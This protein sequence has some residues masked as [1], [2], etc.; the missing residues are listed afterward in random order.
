MTRSAALA[1]LAVFSLVILLP[2][3]VV[4]V[5]RSGVEQSIPPA[6][7]P[8]A[9]SGRAGL[10]EF[11]V[12]VYFHRTG[13]IAALDL[14]EYLAGVVAAEMPA[15]FQLEAM[16]AQAVAARTYSLQRSRS[17]GGK[18]CSKSPYPADLCTDS[19]CCQA[20]VDPGEAAR[21]WPEDK[22]EYYLER[23]RQ[24]VQE[25]AGEVVVYRGSLIE[26]VYHSTC[27]GYTESSTA[28]WSGSAV[29]YLG[30][31]SCP[32]CS[33]SPRFTGTVTLAVPE[34]AALL[35]PEQSVPVASG[36]RLP[37]SV[38]GLTSGGRVDRM[39][40]GDLTLTGR[41]ARRL[42]NLPS[43]AFDVRW[44][45]AG[46]LFA[47]RGYGHGIGLCQYGSDGAAAAGLT[48]TGILAHYYPGTAVTVFGR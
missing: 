48:Y 38:L 12:E 45:D 7:Q 42:F 31:V 3:A 22:R 47:C 10:M 44:T 32:Y 6:P 29:P 23:V 15:S 8:S 24:A 9:P 18:G 2:A 16:K 43:A 25:T 5:G 41:E 17:N 13:E 40:L 14:E 4:S 36:T 39:L 30:G 37:A 35:P 33:H 26:A 34:L 1:L 21:G 46:L 20:W 19:T 28:L 27:G 11:T